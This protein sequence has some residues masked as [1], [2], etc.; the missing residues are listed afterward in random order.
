MRLPRVAACVVLF[1][2]ASGSQGATSFSTDTSAGAGGHGGDATAASSS[3]RAS[4]ASSTGRGPSS[5]ASNGDVGGGAASAGGA[6]GGLGGAGV[7]GAGGATVTSSTGA[8]GDRACPTNQFITGV[9]PNGTLTCSGVD[10]LAATAIDSGCSVYFGWSDGCTGCTT[11]PTKWG[12]VSGTACQN[13]A[14][15][16]DTCTTFDLGGANVL[17]F[18]LNPDGDVDSN[19]KLFSTLHCSAGASST[20]TGPCAAG[21]LATRFDPATGKL[22]CTDAS[23]AVLAYVGGACSLY[24]GIQDSCSGCATPPPKWGFSNDAGCTVGAGTNDTCSVAS[25]GGVNAQLFGLNPSGDVDDNDN[26]YVGLHCVDPAPVSSTGQVGQCPAGQFATAIAADGTLSCAGLSPL[27]EASFRSHCA[28]YFGWQDS[29]DGCTTPPTKWG[30]AKDGACTPGVGAGSLCVTATL[31]GAQ[32]DLYSL[33][34]GG[35]V[36]DN[37]KLHVGFTCQ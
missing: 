16:N 31:N 2:C 14:G 19:D 23:S 21:Q 26:M 9:Q 1:G 24:T 33:N 27:V 30:S 29:C 11:P 36:D 32:V 18:G 4:S 13:G 3:S 35:D 28:V 6:A 22:T 8:T 7:G 10:A 5:S 17:M 15:A 12:D 25:L 34:F 37:D 20:M